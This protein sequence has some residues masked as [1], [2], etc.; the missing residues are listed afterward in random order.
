MDQATIRRLDNHQ[1][2][3]NEKDIKEELKLDSKIYISEKN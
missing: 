3:D 1:N 2:L